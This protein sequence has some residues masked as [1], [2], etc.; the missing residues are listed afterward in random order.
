MEF[1]QGPICQSCGMPL[2]KWRFRN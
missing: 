1:P 2:K